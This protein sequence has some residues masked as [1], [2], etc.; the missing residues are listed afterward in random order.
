M[1]FAVVVL[2]SICKHYGNTPYLHSLQYRLLTVQGD[3][4]LA[5]E[6]SHVVD[7]ALDLRT[8]L[9]P[10]GKEQPLMPGVQNELHRSVVAMTEALVRTL[11][12]CG[13]ASDEDKWKFLTPLNPSLSE[14]AQGTQARILLLCAIAPADFSESL[15]PRVDELL[16]DWLMTAVASQSLPFVAPPPKPCDVPTEEDKFPLFQK[17][18]FALSISAS[19][20]CKSGKVRLVL[21]RLVTCTL[22]TTRPLVAA[23]AIGIGEFIARN[24]NENSQAQLCQHIGYTVGNPPYVRRSLT[25]CLLLYCPV[26]RFANRDPS[27]RSAVH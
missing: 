8:Q 12:Q 18:L 2:S 16:F 9:I 4:V 26:S 24:S 11:C 6:G 23:L 10:E 13:S 20:M 17:V 1:R 14:E 22:D 15:F 25:H 7:M 19:R 27:I 21:D 3:A 5:M